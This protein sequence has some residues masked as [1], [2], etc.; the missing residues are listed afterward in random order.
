MQFGAYS[1]F[2]KQRGLISPSEADG[3]KQ[4][5]AVGS[6]IPSPQLFVAICTAVFRNHVLNYVVRVLKLT[7]HP[8]LTTRIR[9]TCK[10][11]AS[12]IADPN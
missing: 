6:F 2:A 12:K 11:A 7:W 5:C 8:H 3:I 10:Q 4:A 1:E 9:Q